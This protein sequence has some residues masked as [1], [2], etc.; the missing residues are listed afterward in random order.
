MP[1]FQPNAH[2][3]RE[4]TRYGILAAHGRDAADSL[5]PYALDQAYWRSLWW[6]PE[7]DGDAGSAA[8]AGTQ[9]GCE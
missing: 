7:T 1:H 9:E 8:A 6:V 4:L 3:V 5:D 2:Y